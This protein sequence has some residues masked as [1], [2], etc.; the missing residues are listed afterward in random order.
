M[1]EQPGRDHDG[2]QFRYGSAGDKIYDPRRRAWI[3]TRSSTPTRSLEWLG[4]A[5]SVI[6][7][8]LQH[9]EDA[10]LPT[11][12][13]K[14]RAVDEI[15]SRHPTLHAASKLLAQAVRYADI[16]PRGSHEDASPHNGLLSL[17]YASGLN[18]RTAA[19]DS[20]KANLFPI[21]AIPGGDHGEVLCIREMRPCRQGWYDDH[22]S[23]LTTFE[24][25][26]T[27]TIWCGSHERIQQL[28]FADPVEDCS[29]LLGLLYPNSI[30]VFSP[31]ASDTI[32]SH[33]SARIN[34][35]PICT[36]EL[37]SA[38]GTCYTCMAFNP[39][40]QYQIATID[41]KGRW[42]IW[43]IEKSTK[44]STSSHE[45]TV[46]VQGVV[47]VA[48]LDNSDDSG[49][50]NVPWLKVFWIG[51]LSTI[52]LC[53]HRVIQILSFGSKGIRSKSF[54][55]YPPTPQTSV[56]D[57]EKRPSK[58]DEIFVLT[59]SQVLWCRLQ[60]PES[61][62]Q[63]DEVLSSLSVISCWDHHINADDNSLRL[64]LRDGD[65]GSIS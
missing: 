41:G 19:A 1:V 63:G 56:V 47:D 13:T 40:Y 60:S 20:R 57:V 54:N 44:H 50:R 34:P 43:M 23:W 42:G 36:L 17:G 3:A 15:I 28:C 5:E 32:L 64:T 59:T 58:T 31:R 16:R 51:N 53:S 27:E 6:A 61:F 38:D 35:Y 55:F 37:D 21:I 22:G 14:L 7:P 49:A 29:T 10:S 4:L 39:W 25:D 62:G 2:L 33:T 52:A 26:S 46:H 12:N 8:P 18:R 24:I 9:D 30:T 65:E 11:G 45:A 48:L